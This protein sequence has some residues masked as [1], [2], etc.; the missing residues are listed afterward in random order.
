MV[1]KISI[2]QKLN[3]WQRLNSFKEFD[4]RVKLIKFGHWRLISREEQAIF[5]L[6][7]KKKIKSNFRLISTNLKFQL[8][9]W[10]SD[11]NS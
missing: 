11:H 2:L 10:M 9:F 6:E 1:A 4:K 7:I 3:L 8:W 5:N